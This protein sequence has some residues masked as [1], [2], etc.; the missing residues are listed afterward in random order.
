MFPDNDQLEYVIDQHVA[1]RLKYRRIVLGLTR[2]E[3]GEAVNV[4][5]QQIH[6]Y[7]TATNRI[8]SS[9]LFH[10]STF[11]KVPI[12]YFFEMLES[13]GLSSSST[14]AEE[15]LVYDEE[16]N[17]SEREAL[18]LMQ[19]YKKIKPHAIR[20]KILELIDAVGEGELDAKDQQAE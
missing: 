16:S 20:R 12:N 1:Q 2:Q 9:K 6:K 8:S 18:K 17:V 11:L 4:S 7:E 10:L 13:S 5:V 3:V 15:S 19:V 14:L